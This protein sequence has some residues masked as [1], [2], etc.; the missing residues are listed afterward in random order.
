MST[1]VITAQ[2][3]FDFEVFYGQLVMNTKLK[4]LVKESIALN[5]IS[6]FADIPLDS[7]IDRI[8]SI[9]KHA[10]KARYNMEALMQNSKDM[11]EELQKESDIQSITK[12]CLYQK[13]CDIFSLYFIG[14]YFLKYAG[15]DNVDENGIPEYF[16]MR[17][18]DF[19]KKLYPI[20][21]VVCQTPQSFEFIDLL[22]AHSD[23][24]VDD[25]TWVN[26]ALILTMVFL[27]KVRSGRDIT[28]LLFERIPLNIVI[29]DSFKKLCRIKNGKYIMCNT[30]VNSLD[31]QFAVLDL[32]QFI[33][34]N[35]K[36]LFNN[37][38]NEYLKTLKEDHWN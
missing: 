25:W 38:I 9:S 11:L 33:D 24:K 8:T 4:D 37:K 5:T 6:D 2:E 21:Q 36:L 23:E 17:L 22:N 19:I 3:R 15:N 34:H 7:Y 31:F 32:I 26:R 12:E 27:G 20:F 29:P 13:L 14:K 10:R 16:P 18:N 1:R 30:D 35:N 28:R